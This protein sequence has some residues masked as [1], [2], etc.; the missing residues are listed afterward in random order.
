M[1]LHTSRPLAGVKLFHVQDFVRIRSLL[2]DTR[3]RSHVQCTDPRNNGGALYLSAAERYTCLVSA[4]GDIRVQASTPRSGLLRIGKF[5]CIP[6]QRT[7]WMAR[8]RPAPLSIQAPFASI[9]NPRTRAAHFDYWTS[10]QALSMAKRCS[11][12]AVRQSVAFDKSSHLAKAGAKVAAAKNQNSLQV[13]YYGNTKHG[14]VC[15]SP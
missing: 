3:Q 6:V 11:V 13:L 9:T 2:D 10:V 8:G 15:L 4:I 12:W 7:W 5:G 1:G 14:L